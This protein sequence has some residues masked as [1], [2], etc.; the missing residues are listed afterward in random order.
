MNELIND[1][2]K[3]KIKPVYFFDGEESF[4]TDQLCTFFENEILSEAERDFNLDIFYGRDASWS[5][6]V[7]AC[8]SYPSFASRRLVILKEAAQLKEFGKLESY[9][10]NPSPTTLLVIAYKFKKLDQRTSIA[11]TIK[12]NA[13]HLHFEKIKDYKLAEWI[14]N[15]CTRHDV[16][17]SAANAELLA[18]YLGNDL[19]RIANEIEKVLL[20]TP[21]Q[22][23]IN[24]TLIEKHI[25]I[26]KEYNIFE[27]VKAV[28][29]RQS[30]QAFRIVNYYLAN[31]K[32]GSPVMVTAALYNEFDRLYRYHATPHLPDAERAALLR[33]KPF[34]MKDLQF[35]ARQYPVTHCSRAIRLLH[36]YNLYSLGMQS[37]I[38]DVRL[39]KELTVKLLTL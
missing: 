26:S 22:R 27:F 24:E 8:R 20:N 25:G 30:E 11:K 32:E 29:R 4:Y 36:Q 19:Q 5:D 16:V 3:G 15:Y 18:A 23:E 7:N 2:H 21:G 12:S 17:I 6:I 34:L 33:I 31:P 35:Y 38:N 28:M 37:A 9:L 14:Q 1:V 39:L 10:K 13:V